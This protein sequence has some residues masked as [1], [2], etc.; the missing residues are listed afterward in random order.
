MPS[1]LMSGP[2]N[3][4]AVGAGGSPAAGRAGRVI[5]EVAGVCQATCPFCAQNSAKQRRKEVAGAAYMPVELFRKIVSHLRESVAF[6]QKVDR[7]YLYNWGEPFLCPAI[8][9]YLEILKE[10]GLYA[11]ISS[12]FQKVPVIRPELLPVID[13]V[14]FSLSGMTQDTY[15]QI[16]GGQ[17]DKVLKNFE[18]FREQMRQHAPKSKLFMAWHRYRFNEHQFWPAY[19]YSRKQG[20][21][22]IPSVA[23][24]NDLPEL[25]QAASDKMPPARKADAQKSLYFEHMVNSFRQYRDGGALYDCPA[26]DDVVVDEQGRLMICCGTDAKTA[27]GTVFDTSYDQMRQKKI[28]SALCKVCKTTGVAEWAHNNH[29]D[30][31]QLPW[32]SG[33][34]L[35]ALRLRLS[36]DRLKLKNDARHAL[37]KVAFGEAILDVYRKFRHS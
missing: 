18:G 3:I 19:H 34:G 2:S 27:V 1:E 17:I 25:I 6:V 33:G 5:I 7:V 10:H 22:F 20:V 12:N 32:P 15:G 16:H 36:Y 28:A 4:Q 8:N 30:R 14:L 24:L 35:G 26:W 29:H 37:N 23:F 9:E 11:V 31:N 13:E 21:G